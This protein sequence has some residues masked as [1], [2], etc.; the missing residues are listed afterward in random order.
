M[1]VTQAKP[2]RL[3]P[4]A[5]TFLAV[6]QELLTPAIWKQ[7]EQARR[8]GRRPPRWRAQPLVL[9]LLVTTW[10]CGDSQ[11]E[12]FETAKGFVGACL[13]KRRRPGR[14]VQGFQRALSQLPIAV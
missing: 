5:K 11:A 6:L 13:A 10:C 7:A 14:S 4:A 12:R 9:C 3:R 8:A 2:R 1:N